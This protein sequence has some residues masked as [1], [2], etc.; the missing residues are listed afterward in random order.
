M[1]FSF[2]SRIVRNNL[3]KMNYIPQISLSLSLLTLLFVYEIAI[4]PIYCCCCSFGA[5]AISFHFILS[6]FLFESFVHFAAAAVLSIV[7][8]IF[9]L[10]AI[11]NSWHNSTMEP[12]HCIWHMIAYFTDF[13]CHLPLV[14][15]TISTEQLCFSCALHPFPNEL[16]VAA[17]QWYSNF[18]TWLSY[19]IISPSRLLRLNCIWTANR[20][21]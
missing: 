14:G 18:K 9:D 11:G 4:I 10:I 6:S 12:T 15:K 7:F 19:T 8:P 13:L 21:K 2:P 20:A 16:C 3:F 17:L 5:V 1:I